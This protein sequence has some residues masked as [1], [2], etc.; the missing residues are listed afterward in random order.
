MLEMAVQ[1][2]YK[3]VI[4]PVAMYGSE[5]W[6]LRKDEQEVLNRTEMRMLRWVMGIKRIK[7]KVQTLCTFLFKNCIVHLIVVNI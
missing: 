7:K 4:R 6:T 5:T 2:L 1:V 3:S